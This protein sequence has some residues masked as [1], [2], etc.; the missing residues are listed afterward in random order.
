MIAKVFNSNYRQDCNH[1]ED[2]SY[3]RRFPLP[4][5]KAIRVAG[6]TD[7]AARIGRWPSASAL[8][9]D[10]YRAG[11]PGGTGEVFDWASVPL[12]CER[13]L[14]LAGG[15]SAA[16]VGLAIAATSPYAVD[17][18]GGVEAAPGIK[19][20]DAMQSFVDAVKAADQ[21]SRN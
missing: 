5:M 4:F 2:D 18:S 8:L 17:V 15:L 10:T 13:P 11:T 14:V 12:D 21:K 1:N 9:L 7:V 6:D 16:N 20:L 3:C 19:D